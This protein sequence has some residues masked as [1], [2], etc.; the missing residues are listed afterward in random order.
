MP[1]VKCS[2]RRQPPPPK[3][4]KKKD[5]REP[6]TLLGPQTGPATSPTNGARPREAAPT[7]VPPRLDVPRTVCDQASKD[8]H[9]A[10][11]NARYETLRKMSKEIHDEMDRTTYTP[12]DRASTEAFVAVQLKGDDI[13]KLVREASMDLQRAKAIRVIKCNGKIDPPKRTKYKKGGGMIQIDPP[14]IDMRAFMDPPFKAGG[15]I[16]ETVCSET[17]KQDYQYFAK[18]YLQDAKARAVET[19]REEAAAQRMPRSDQRTT[20]LDNLAKQSTRNWVA[21]K[22]ARE[23]VARANAIRVIICAKK[24]ELSPPT[25]PKK[26]IIV[27]PGGG[28]TGGGTSGGGT[29]EETPPEEDTSGNGNTDDTQKMIRDPMPPITTTPNPQPKTG[30]LIGPQ[31]PFIWEP[32]EQEPQEVEPVE[33][34]PEETQPCTPGGSGGGMVQI[35]PPVLVIHPVTG[36]ASYVP[37][38]QLI[39]EGALPPEGAITADTPTGIDDD[40]N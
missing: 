28:T 34:L 33:V 12:G 17:I 36:E 26:E 25:E 37:R 39:A 5:P 8:A 7:P 32:M 21:I 4:P 22:A 40:C 18:K 29:S 31:E 9:I 2:D 19:D 16:P 11:L 15:N 27:V 10:R 23:D 35:D 6:K 20:I 38:E 1:V 30:Y 14:Q 24:K 13:R 3:E